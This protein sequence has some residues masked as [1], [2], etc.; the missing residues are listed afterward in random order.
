MDTKFKKKAVALSIIFT[1]L[2]IGYFY[3]IST[4]D[5]FARNEN[6]M[7]S[8]KDIKINHTFFDYRFEKF[9]DKEKRFNLFYTKLPSDIVYGDEKVPVIIINFFNYNC[10]FCV[11]FENEVFP[12]LKENYID[13]KLVKLV[14]RPVDTKKTL[15]LTTSLQCLKDDTVIRDIH[16]EFFNIN[17]A[18]I[19]TLESFIMSSI[20]K[21]KSDLDE[22]YFK[23]CFINQQLFEQLVYLQLNNEKFFHINGTPSFIVN[24]KEHHGFLNYDELSKIIDEELKE[25]N[26]L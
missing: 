7:Q 1:C 22:K 18:R 13:K 21:Y 17:N 26:V 25:K 12:K 8:T 5:S 16:K 4:N 20:K 10:H 15:L 23:D 11:K 3:R 2:I 6:T 24:E 19:K 14:Y 9:T